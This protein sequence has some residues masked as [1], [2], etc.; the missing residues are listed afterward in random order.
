MPEYV[1]QAEFEA[2]LAAAQG[3]AQ[4]KVPPTSGGR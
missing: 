3:V 2:M 4:A 1:S